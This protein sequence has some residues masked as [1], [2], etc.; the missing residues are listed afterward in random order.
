MWDQ[1]HQ[2]L[3]VNTPPH[4][5]APP[6]EPEA[7]TMQEANLKNHIYSMWDQIHQVL[8]VNTPPHASAPPNGPEAWTMQE[9]N[10]KNHIYPTLD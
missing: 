10:L 7:W 4:A 9:A 1:I 3:A 5:S 8:A 2:V 6:N